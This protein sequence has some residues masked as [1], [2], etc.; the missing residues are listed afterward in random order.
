MFPNWR[1]DTSAGV[2]FEVSLDWLERSSTTPQFVP[3]LWQ[4]NGRDV[5]SAQLSPAQPSSPPCFVKHKTFFLPC[6]HCDDSTEITFMFGRGIYCRCVDGILFFKRNRE[7]IVV[8]VSIYIV[9]LLSFKIKSIFFS[10]TE[11]LSVTLPPSGE[12]FSLVMKRIVKEDSLHQ[13]HQNENKMDSLL[14]ISFIPQRFRLHFVEK[15]KYLT[16]L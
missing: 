7:N 13:L 3:M 12:C 14:G 15:E 10:L 16:S 11:W 5:H 9:I 6:D 4:M 8:L 2:K 1:Q